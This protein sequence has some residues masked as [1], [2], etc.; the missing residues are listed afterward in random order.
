MLYSGTAIFIKSLR[1]LQIT[2][3]LYLQKENIFQFCFILFVFGFCLFVF[4]FR[5]NAIY[6]LFYKRRPIEGENRA[7]F[8]SSSL[9]LFS[10]PSYYYPLQLQAQSA[11][12]L[13][14]FIGKI[15]FHLSYK[16]D[17][18]FLFFAHKSTHFNFLSSW[19]FLK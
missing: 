3:S 15:S 1:S 16:P 14:N 13:K 12:P 2:C 9:E 7:D 4:Q 11:E 10:I 18:G 19:N 17:G 5:V 6:Q 8:C